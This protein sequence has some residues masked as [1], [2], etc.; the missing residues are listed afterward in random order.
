MPPTTEV[1]E[2]TLQVKFDDG[3]AKLA[4]LDLATP[5]VAIQGKGA[6][7]LSTL[8]FAATLEASVSEELEQLDPACRVD[9]RYTAL[10]LPV[11][12]AGNLTDETGNLCRVDVEDIARQ[13]LENE[14]RSKLEEKAGSALRKLFG[15]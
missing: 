9:E 13:L 11:N 8:D 12:C 4:R 3:Q 5:G 15:R 6:A 10:R 7:S 1:A 2:M 14:A